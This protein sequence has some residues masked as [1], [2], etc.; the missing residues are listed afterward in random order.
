MTQT[1]P[2]GSTPTSTEEKPELLDV[3]R[4]LMPERRRSTFALSVTPSPPSGSSGGDGECVAGLGDEVADA[5]DSRDV[6]RCRRTSGDGTVA[7]DAG[8]GETWMDGEGVG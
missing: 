8:R 3:G 1:A 6:T 4:I 2:S 7:C 5:G